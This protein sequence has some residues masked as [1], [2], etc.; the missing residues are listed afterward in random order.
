[1]K[2]VLP[3]AIAVFF[4]A[5]V[6]AQTDAPVITRA[7]VTAEE[8]PAASPTDTATLDDLRAQNK[9][10]SSELALSWKENEE[11]KNTVLGQVAAANQKAETAEAR[12]ASATNALVQSQAD[13]DAKTKEVADLNAQLANAQKAAVDPAAL[14]A[15]QNDL[16][17]EKQKVADI[18]A[19]RDDLAQKLAQAQTAATAAPPPPPPAASPESPDLQKEAADA[20]DKLNMSLRAYTLLQSENDQLK[21]TLA[22]TTDDKNS[23]AAQLDDT[24]H[25]ADDRQVTI[26]QQVQLVA[27]LQAAAATDAKNIDALHDQLRQMQ[28]LVSQLA[29]ENAELKTRLVLDAP[30]PSTPTP[31]SYTPAP[32]LAPSPDAPATTPAAATP[33]PDATGPRTYKVVSGDTLAKISKQFYGTSTR[34]QQILDANH[35]KLHSDKS[36]RVGMELKIP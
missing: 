25:T 36:L 19:E 22:K 31:P 30:S 3:L 16:A 13:L 33:S 14:A 20:E 18:Q 1:M 10:L 11:L 8:T 17:T 28:N 26:N 23:L 35:D 2:S 4:A 34:W 32:A 7:P 29:A 5:A 27:S 21:D 6:H 24:K 15:I 12:T 9:K